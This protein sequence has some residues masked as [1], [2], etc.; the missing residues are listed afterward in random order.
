MDNAKST[1]IFNYPSEFNDD[2][3]INL[4]VETINEIYSQGFKK[5]K[6]VLSDSPEDTTYEKII[7]LE[8]LYKIKNLQ[9]LPEFVVRDFLIA[10][11]KLK[12]T[13]FEK[14]IKL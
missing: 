3:E 14:R 2:G 12:N 4:P 5:I 6:L 13:N 1:D 9:K 11:G 8:L 10:K 7:D